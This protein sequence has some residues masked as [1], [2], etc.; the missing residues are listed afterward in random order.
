M[1]DARMWWLDATYE[2]REKFLLDNGFNPRLARYAWPMLPY[3][4]QGLLVR[5]HNDEP[6]LSDSG[7]TGCCSNCNTQ[8]KLDSTHITCPNCGFKGL[9]W[10]F[11]GKD[12]EPMEPSVE[13]EIQELER[14]WKL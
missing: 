9:L 5:M 3:S 6:I 7:I 14:L 10:A 4:V 2:V 8:Y 1:N 11:H 12:A 13:K